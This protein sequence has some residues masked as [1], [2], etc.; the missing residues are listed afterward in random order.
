M[1]DPWIIEEIRRREERE[2]REEQPVLEIPLERPEIE[3]DQS[4]VREHEEEE[5]ERGVVIVDFRVYEAASKLTPPSAANGECP[6]SPSTASL[7]RATS[8][9]YLYFSTAARRLQLTCG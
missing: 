5:V 2:R 3:E 8:L 1:L 9:I 7:G 4:E 6:V